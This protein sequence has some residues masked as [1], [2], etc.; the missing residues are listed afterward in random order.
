[1]TIKMLVGFSG[2]DFSVSPGEV[3][4]RFSDAEEARM[5]AAEYAVLD[6]PSEPIVDHAPAR[7]PRKVT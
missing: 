4:D 1:M 3:T 6:A 2:A 5:I 7:K